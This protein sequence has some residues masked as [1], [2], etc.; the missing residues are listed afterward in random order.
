MRATQAPEKWQLVLNALNTGNIELAHKLAIKFEFDKDH[1]V[2]RRGRTSGY[3]YF[4]RD[5]EGKVYSN[6]NASALSRQFGKVSSYVTAMIGKRK[7]RPVLNGD[8]KGWTFWKE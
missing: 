4:A 3:T 6:T 8:L 5:T 2:E 7:G 1:Q